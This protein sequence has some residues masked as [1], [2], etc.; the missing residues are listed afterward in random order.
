MPAKRAFPCICVPQRYN[1]G[2]V[3][4]RLN[5][6]AN[7]NPMSALHVPTVLPMQKVIGAELSMLVAI[8]CGTK[9]SPKITTLS[10]ITPIS[11][12]YRDVLTRP[13]ALP[14]LT[15]RGGQA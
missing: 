15:R 11:G 8:F 9:Q 2:S 10:T 12:H 6:E 7:T 14:V 13:R 1:L 3:D 4:K 5:G